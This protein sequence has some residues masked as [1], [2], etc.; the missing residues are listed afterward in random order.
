MRLIISSADP[1]LSRMLYLET[2]RGA[3]EETV[4][5]VTLCLLDLDHPNPTVTP[6]T[7]AICVGF[8]TS[9]ESVG[10][11]TRA[12]L[13]ALLSLPFSARA[14]DA[15]LQRLFP[16]HVD[17]FLLCSPQDL[18]LDGMKIHLSKIEAA[19]FALL[20]ENRERVVS[21]AEIATVLGDSATKANTP[22]VYLYRLRQKLCADGKERIRTV[23]GKG[24]R[25]VGEVARSV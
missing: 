11:A 5:D 6:E 16:R 8:S 13:A 15:T 20:Y 3:L 12:T 9:P 17:C 25:W 4:P 2:K 14:F 7:G 1:V 24:A 21:D 22:A 23:R 10:Q 18:L 19:L